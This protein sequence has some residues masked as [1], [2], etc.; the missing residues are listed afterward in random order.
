MLSQCDRVGGGCCR[1]HATCS[2][3]RVFLRSGA[4]FS[5]PPKRRR[6]SIRS[7][8]PQVGR[9][10]TEEAISQTQTAVV[11]IISAARRPDAPSGS[12]RG[13]CSRCVIGS[14]VVVAAAIWAANH[15]ERMISTK[16]LACASMTIVRGVATNA[17]ASA[18]RGFTFA[19]QNYRALAETSSRGFE[20]GS[21][22]GPLVVGLLGAKVCSGICTTC[23]QT[24]PASREQQKQQAP[25]AESNELVHT[26]AKPSPTCHWY[27]GSQRHDHA[28]QVLMTGHEYAPLTR[29]HEDGT[30]TGWVSE[31]LRNMWPQLTARA[32]ECILQAIS[33]PGGRKTCPLHGPCPMCGCMH[34]R[35]LAE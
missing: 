13:R 20:S 23:D 18:A 21:L 17:S 35:W 27:W 31:L 24:A 34:A 33:K 5:M 9:N 4:S 25:D 10:R 14:V 32:R 7:P 29:G 22:I 12:G 8:L 15:P 26:S 28:A 2:A 16:V 30:P 3:T 1:C 6:C 11:K 19:A